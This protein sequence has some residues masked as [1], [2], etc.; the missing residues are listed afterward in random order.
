MPP[1]LEQVRSRIRSVSRNITIAE[2][3]LLDFESAEDMERTLSTALRELKSLQIT[4]AVMSRKE[5][6]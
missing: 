1:R 5:A 4:V 6:C 2:G 3:R